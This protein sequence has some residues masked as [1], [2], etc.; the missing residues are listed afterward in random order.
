MP[1]MKSTSWG[2]KFMPKVKVLR[3]VGQRSLPRSQ[4]QNCW[5][6][7]KGL[8]TK[9]VHMKSLMVQKLLQQLKFSEM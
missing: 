8:T 3:Y 6:D 1:N 5:H 4:G 2:S 7:Q 9:N